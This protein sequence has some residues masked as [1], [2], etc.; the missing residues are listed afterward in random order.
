MRRG[1]PT[2][3]CALLLATACVA[4]G[5]SAPPVTP[6]P[7][8]PDDVPL[9]VVSAADLSSPDQ[10]GVRQSL[11]DEWNEDSPVKA[12][13]VELPSTDGDARAEVLAGLQ[14]GA[15]EY[16]VL[17]LDITWIPEF[18]EAGLLRPLDEERFGAL[19]F[20]A[21]IEETGR[22]DDELYAV[23]FNTDVGLLYYRRDLTETMDLGADSLPEMYTGRPG[24][25]STPTYVT[26]L[27]PYEGLTVNVLE[28]MWRAAPDARLVDDS[29]AYVGTTAVLE[30]GLEEL[31]AITDESHLAAASYGADESGTLEEFAGEDR[32]AALMRN[33]PF[34]LNR[35]ADR[36]VAEGV[37]FG[38]TRLPGPAALGGQ[39]LAV[40]AS[41]PRAEAAQELIR[42]LTGEPASQER[43]LAAGF[44]P[45]LSEAYQLP[46]DAGE[47]ACEDEL[48]VET[49][50][51]PGPVGQRSE[52]AGDEPLWRPDPRDYAT[53]LWCAV[54][55]ARGRPATPYYRQFSRVIEEEVTRLLAGGAGSAGGV[56]DAAQRIDSRLELAL[57]G[58]TYQPPRST[59]SSH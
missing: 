23:P 9:V 2:A 26:Q 40:A 29:G 50:D 53:L 38:V 4:G 34:A 12:R 30:A 16:D 57:R 27:R 32:G 46:D 49:P 18:A 3:A 31:L 1:V 22:W 10:S 55:E 36:L 24:G 59:P 28:A 11:I 8:P 7:T 42:F 58:R 35:V 52:E 5:G 51:A 25:Q 6:G 45:A 54:H 39:S 21:D 37:P 15:A 48:R 19:D 33:W 13:L 17:N 20:V 14:S 44:A 47:I 41:S 43:L 56:E